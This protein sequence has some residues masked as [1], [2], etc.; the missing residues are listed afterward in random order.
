MKCWASGVA[1]YDIESMIYCYVF[2][3]SVRSFAAFPIFQKPCILK[4]V[5][6]RVKRTKI[7]TPGIVNERR[8]LVTVK[9]SR[10]L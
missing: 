3:I 9:G 1:N 6:R 2:K 8:V 5:G 10:L 4:I 7:W